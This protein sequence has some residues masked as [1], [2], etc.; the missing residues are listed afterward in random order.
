MEK[1]AGGGGFGEGEARRKLGNSSFVAAGS[2]SLQQMG[3]R[4]KETYLDIVPIASRE[5]DIGSSFQGI[6][7]QKVYDMRLSL[8]DMGLSIEL[9]DHAIQ[10][11]R[12]QGDANDIA[13]FALSLDNPPA[14]CI[15]EP[16]PPGMVGMV[17][18]DEEEEI[19]PLKV[20]PII[21]LDNSGAGE[22]RS[23]GSNPVSLFELDDTYCLEARLQDMGFS[24]EDVERAVQIH[25]AKTSE[26]VLVQF[27]LDWQQNHGKE[28]NENSHDVPEPG[29][30]EGSCSIPH[31][32][33]T[34]HGDKCLHM[35]GPGDSKFPDRDSDTDGSDDESES[36]E[37]V[38]SG[39]P[40]VHVLHITSQQDNGASTSHSLSAERVNT[41]EKLV[42]LTASKFSV[43]AVERAVDLCHCPRWNAEEDQIGILLDFLDAHG[44]ELEKMTDTMAT[45]KGKG[46]RKQNTCHTQSPKY[47]SIICGSY[48]RTKAVKMSCLIEK[49]PKYKRSE[50]F[51]L[52]GQPVIPRHLSDDIKGAPYFYFENVASMPKGQWERIQRHLFDI[53]PEFVDSMHFSACRRPRGYIHNLPIEGRKKLSPDPPMTIQE[54]L[55]ETQQFWPSWDPRTK[56]NCINTRKGSEFLI[57]RMELDKIPLNPRNPDTD[58]KTK[59]LEQCKKWNLVWTNPSYPTP[60][61]E[62]EIE[63]MLGFDKDHSRYCYNT[64]AR[65]LALGNSFS[66]YTVAFHFSVLKALYPRGIKA[67]GRGELLDLVKRYGG[68]D[69]IVGGSP[70]NNLS[71]N[72]MWTRVGLDGDKSGVFFE[73]SRIVSALR[74]FAGFDM[75]R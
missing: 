1:G 60:I 5:P 40:L 62:N 2:T 16:V 8:M 12:G 39:M 34:M 19:A 10:A 6:T 73:F 68:F 13:A 18:S 67:L 21:Q 59:I 38:Q 74:E 11:C 47:R 29:G 23:E 48:R 26:S 25:G 33:T 53:E 4:V 42:G 72:N 71:G 44:D 51:G 32:H 75:H 28:T 56:L 46:K 24:A 35:L 66:I 15:E 70:C 20:D 45:S 54:L 50:G 65:F 22:P 9:I 3:A 58:Q 31:S 7:S 37:G 43:N 55:P 63:A 17:S 64:S 49:P 61:T 52:P 69:L 27:L 41:V 57:R 36:D 30:H 14:E